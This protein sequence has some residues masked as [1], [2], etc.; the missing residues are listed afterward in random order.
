MISLVLVYFY[1]GAVGQ[2]GQNGQNGQAKK[3]T[4]KKN[5]LVEMAGKFKY[6]GENGQNGQANK[7]TLK[8]NWG[9]FLSV[10]TRTSSSLS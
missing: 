5:L 1:P 4:L 3:R 7:R 6:F 9:K 10:K 8:K 2:N